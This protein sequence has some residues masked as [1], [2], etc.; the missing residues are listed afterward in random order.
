MIKQAVKIFKD[1][2]QVKGADNYV[3][4]LTPL[5]E[6][7]YKHLPQAKLTYDIGCAYGIM[8]LAC[9]LRGDDVVAM[10]MTAKYTNLE[11]FEKEGIKFEKW[12]IEKQAMP[13]TQKADLVIF[14]EILEHLNSNPL[15]T[16]KKLYN[17]LDTGGYVVCSTPAKE[18]WGET[19]GMNAQ[20]GGKPP[21]L[22]NDLDSWR[23]IPEYKGKWIDGHMY[24]FDQ[25]DLVSLFSEAGFKVE[26]VKIISDFSH[27]L[28]GKK[29]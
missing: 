4:G 22:W 28:I 3:K 12:N 9:K 19:A 21:G 8:S 20:M 23:D 7:I 27:L 14:T 1:Y 16:V 5:Y 29:C 2:K 17:A 11:M 6:E 26:D 24:H 13:V 25:F 10:D 15:P 18:L